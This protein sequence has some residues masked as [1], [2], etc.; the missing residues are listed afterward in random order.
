MSN[1]SILGSQ[2]DLAQK[3]NMSLA[4][5]FLNVDLVALVDISGSMQ[6][7]DAGNGKSRWDVAQDHLT[8]L[9]GKYQGKIALIE[10]ASFVEFRPNGKLSPANGGTNLTDALKFVKIADD[11][12]IKIIVVSDG[13]PDNEQTALTQ[14]TRFTSKIDAIYCG[15]ENDHEGGRAFLQRL[16][17][18]TGGQLITSVTTGAI[19]D[20]LET[21]LL[22]G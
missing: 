1:L 7:N 8:K 20:G 11:C 15:D 21:L 9:Q 3:N 14:A 10:F 19:G 12:G 18:A 4:E 5:T 13:K 16:V 17:N 2:S 6:T 22:G